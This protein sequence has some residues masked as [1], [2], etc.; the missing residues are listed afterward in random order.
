[1]DV[2]IHTPT[3][4]A[5]L[6]LTDGALSRLRE[7]KASRDVVYVILVCPSPN[8]ERRPLEVIIGFKLSGDN[9]N[10]SQ[11]GPPAP[12]SSQSISDTTFLSS[13]RQCGFSIRRIKLSGWHDMEHIRKLAVCVCLIFN[14]SMWD[15]DLAAAQRVNKHHHQPNGTAAAK[16]GVA[17]NV[18]EWA[19]PMSTMPES[20]AVHG[21][22]FFYEVSL[23]LWAPPLPPL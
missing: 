12:A 22:R 13:L 11:T 5:A 6:V 18:I 21:V 2:N 20:R 14:T 23:R 19:K 10:N 8:E 17:T 15:V 7:A 16:Q 3:E 4:P 9:S 1:M